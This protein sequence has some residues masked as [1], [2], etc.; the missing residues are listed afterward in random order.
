MTKI[1]APPAANAREPRAEGET[2]EQWADR[3]LAEHGPI[4]DHIVDRLRQVITA[5]NAELARARGNS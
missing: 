5:A 4:P 1:T 3:V 2:A